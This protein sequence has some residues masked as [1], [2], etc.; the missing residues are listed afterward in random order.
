MQPKVHQ[1]LLTAA[2]FRFAI[3]ASRWNDFLT[4]KLVE[5][6]L[7]ALERLGADEKSIEIF[8][9]PGSFELPLTALKVAQGGRFDAVI[10]IGTVIR[11]ET[12]HFEYVAGEAAKG[13]AQASMQTG[14]PVLFGV[15]T[16]DTLEQA[17]NRTGVKSGNKGF[18]V[19]MSAVELVN[20]YKTMDGGENLGKEKVFPHVV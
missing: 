16:T 9:V 18:E 1:G 2:G 8:K 17:I 19:A 13:V 10:C 12:P 6:A 20:L 11:G 7:D 3:I 4:S 5:G 14:I 15:V